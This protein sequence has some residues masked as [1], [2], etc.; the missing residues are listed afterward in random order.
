ML[1]QM[2]QR[3]KWIFYTAMH[4]VGLL[5]DERYS[6]KCAKIRYA[7]QLAAA[8]ARFDY[9]AYAQ[10]VIARTD[11]KVPQEFV[12]YARDAYVRDPDDAKIIAFY[13]PQFHPIEEN[14]LWHGRGFTEWFNVAQAVPQFVG[15]HQPQLPIDVGFYDLTHPDVMY[16]QVELAH[17]YGVYGFCFHYY[18]FS[19]RRLLEKPLLNWLRCKDLNLPFCLCWANENWSRQWDGGDRDILLK[20]ELREGDAPRFFEDLAPYLN[21]ARYIRI[22]NRPLI[23]IYR[24]NLH[25]KEKFLAFVQ[26]LRECARVAHLPGL[27]LCTV[28]SGWMLDEDPRT[29]GLDGAVG[30]PPHDL[31]RPEYLAH[32][33]VTHARSTIRVYDLNRM[34]EDGAV[35]TPCAASGCVFPGIVAGWDNSARKAK[36]QG[37]AFLLTPTK[38]QLWLEK[39]LR[40]MRADLP[41]EQQFVFVN[42]WNEWAEGAHLEPDTKHGYAFLDATR[43]ALQKARKKR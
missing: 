23:L 16:R 14:N 12:A 37:V 28:K 13:L 32:Q 25:E 20:Q 17:R 1:R 5:D 11:R 15:H 26:Q 4:G 42:A 9:S 40:K 34:V 29:W 2:K 39:L 7:Q 18:W 35:P 19:G 3:I 21:D 6:S 8:K 24:P 43:H 22:D 10:A 31:L 36:S 30:F 27:F 38:Y 33:V 41:P